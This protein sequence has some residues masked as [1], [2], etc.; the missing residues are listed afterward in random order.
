MGMASE[1]L[2]TRVA[3]IKADDRYDKGIGTGIKM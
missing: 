1:E 3:K 2:E